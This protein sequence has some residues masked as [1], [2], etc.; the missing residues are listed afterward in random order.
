MIAAMKS[1]DINAVRVPLNE[2]CWL[3]IGT[4]PGRGGAPYRR[5]V[6]RYVSALNRAGLYV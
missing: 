3:G 6:K 2:D 5:I 4:K 1:W